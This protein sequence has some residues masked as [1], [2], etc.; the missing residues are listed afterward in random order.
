MPCLGQR[1][2]SS[3][4]I[5]QTH[6][7]THVIDCFT[8]TT[9]LLG[10]YVIYERLCESTMLQFKHQPRLFLYISSSDHSKV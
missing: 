5:V 10:N 3:K 8:W 6:R 4:A 7:Q 9:K 1:S 2:F